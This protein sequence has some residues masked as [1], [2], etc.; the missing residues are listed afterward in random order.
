MQHGR[1]RMRDLIKVLLAAVLLAAATAKAAEI[2]VRSAALHLANEGLVLDAE[3][4]FQFPPRLA[5]AVESG[6]SLYFLV[7]FEMSRPRWY[8]LDER[9]AAKRLQLQ[10]SYHAL[11][12]QYAVSSGPLEQQFST[13]EEALGVLR[14]VRNWVVADR[15]A[16]VSDARYDAAVRMRLDTSLLP[17]PIQ[18]SA[19]TNREWAFESEWGHFEYRSPQM[20][21]PVETREVPSVEAT[22]Q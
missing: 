9:A 11:S 17:K 21:A 8:W 13:L 19:L 22:G 16:L 15:I 3:F 14:H 2:E 20:Q 6:V 18:V 1:R 12:R 7:E 10:L 4:S 5:E